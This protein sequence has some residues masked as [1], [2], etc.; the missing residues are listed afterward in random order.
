MK[1]GIHSS[2]R[3][4]IRE[5]I[6]E[7]YELTPFDIARYRR[8]THSQQTDEEIRQ[9][10][11]HRGIG[12]QGKLP[13]QRDKQAM[14]DWHE[15]MKQNPQFVKK[16]M[17]GQVQILHSL[18]YRGT[19]SRKADLN[20][21]GSK[22][23]FS[24]WIKTFGMSSRDQLSCVAANAPIGSDPRIWE[25]DIGNASKAYT[26]GYGFLLKGYPAF[27][28]KHDIMTQT[29]SAIP[30]TLRDF[31]K[32]SGQVKRTYSMDPA[33]DPKDWKGIDELILDNWQIIGV[34]ITDR[35][36]RNP[37]KSHVIADALS[38]GI[39]VWRSNSGSGKME[40]I[41]RNN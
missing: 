28:A 21:F 17:E 16:F 41:Q 40:M 19:Y 39:P 7:D 5:L 1:T 25:W 27:G 26:E 4:I 29:L 6:L 13:I 37:S 32:N 33:I 3:Q 34:Y 10:A 12:I 30:D 35:Y 20:D 22:T 9:N 11:D 18:T 2:L 31:H 38:L 36:F 14:R 23:P 24:D 8:T 15:L